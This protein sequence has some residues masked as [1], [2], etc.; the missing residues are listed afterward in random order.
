ML[1]GVLNQFTLHCSNAICTII[2]TAIFGGVVYAG[3]RTVDYVNRALMLGKLSVYLI[4]VLFLLPHINTKELAGGSL[5]AV[6]SNLMILITSFGFASIVPSLRYYFQDDIPLLRRVIFWGSIIPLFCYVI[7]LA[8]V[9]GVVSVPVLQQISHSTNPIAD[10]MQVLEQRFEAGWIAACFTV[11][12]VICILTAFLGVSLGLFDLIADG[13][14]FKKRGFQG[15]V[16]F[17]LTFLPPMFLVLINP[18]IY[19]MALSY[20]GIFCVLLLLV[21]P[22]AMAWRQRGAS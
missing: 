20:A 1:G 8:A 4:V 15:A 5:Q 21:L 16:V 3:I 17:A 7:W 2:F 11:F 19:M 9:M 18:G 14:H 13:V 22:A 12:S 10:L 6:P